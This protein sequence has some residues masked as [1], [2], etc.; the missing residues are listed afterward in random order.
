VL[1]MGKNDKLVRKILSGSS[2][3]N[4][5]F[6]ELRYLLK[7]LGFEE[8]IKGSHHVFRKPGVEEKINL[9][10]DADKAKPYQV[11]QVRSMLVGYRLIDGD[12]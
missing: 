3:A 2:D 1:R 4:I 11:R 7:R 12:S 10:R 6:D 5:D 8:R 9:Q